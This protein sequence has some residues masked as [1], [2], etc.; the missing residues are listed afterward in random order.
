MIEVTPVW[1]RWSCMGTLLLC[2]CERESLCVGGTLKVQKEAEALHW[3]QTIQE[4]LSKPK[5]ELW[6]N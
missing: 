6:V 4:R 2:M 3:Q 1:L 5:T